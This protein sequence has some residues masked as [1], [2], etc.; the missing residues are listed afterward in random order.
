MITP[1]ECW[2]QKRCKKYPNC[3][4]DFCLKLFKIDE[5][6]TRALLTKEQRHKK[7]LWLDGN[8]LDKSAF[9]Y[10]KGIED[11]A[12]KFVSQGNNLYIYSPI[13]GNGKTAWSL[14]I[15]L[16]YI[17]KCWYKADIK[18]IALFVNIPRF[19]L[20]LKHNISEYDQ[21]Y[22]DVKEAI[23]DADLVVF[24]ELGTKIATSFE[25]EHLLSIINARIDNKKSN[26]FTSNLD[27]EDLRKSV[28]DRMYSR[29]VNTSTLVM[30]RGCDKRA[31]NE[32]E[33]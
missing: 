1:S 5:L 24:D 9:T 32:P 14:R 2:I 28:G 19:L 25:I 29:I 18:S 27:P 7:K 15:L 23:L 16:S 17:E 11:N 10:L 33:D 12:E 26:I 30:F 4:T 31:I 8:G 6:C 21:Y 3:D 22:N 20:S 13:T